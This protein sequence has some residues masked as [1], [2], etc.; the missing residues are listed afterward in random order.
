MIAVLGSARRDLVAE[1]HAVPTAADGV[2]V[3]KTASVVMEENSRQLMRF[4]VALCL[5][6]S[7]PYVQRRKSDPPTFLRWTP[8]Y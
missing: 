2:G 7:D 8:R 6:R 5:T 1:Q 4:F 3:D